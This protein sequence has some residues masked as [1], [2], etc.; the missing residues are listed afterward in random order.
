MDGKEL[1]RL[2]DLVQELRRKAD[3]FEQ[4]VKAADTEKAQTEFRSKADSYREA[5][6][7][8]QKQLRKLNS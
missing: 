8:L 3:S 1:L 6:E 7:E 2:L 4:D 5:A